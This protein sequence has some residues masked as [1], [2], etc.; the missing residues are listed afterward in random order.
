[1][2]LDQII[3]QYPDENFLIADGFDNAIIGLDEK[4]MRLIKQ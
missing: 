1:M 4:T 3:E 2:M